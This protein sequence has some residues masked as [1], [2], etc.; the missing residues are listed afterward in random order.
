MKLWEFYVLT[1]F[2]NSGVMATR[3]Q[4]G[5]EESHHDE[6]MGDRAHEQPESVI[7]VP[8]DEEAGENAESV[9]SEPDEQLENEFE[10]TDVKD[11]GETLASV[12]E[13]QDKPAPETVRQRRPNSMIDH[14]AVVSETAEARRRTKSGQLA[15]VTRL[16]NEID[17]LMV[18]VTNAN[19]VLGKLGA[20]DVAFERLLIACDQC[21]E[22]TSV[23]DIDELILFERGE[24]LKQRQFVTN[25]ESWLQSVRKVGG[26]GDL[27]QVGA[28]SQARPASSLGS[29]SSRRSH[30]STK[31]AEAQV[32][33]AVARM[34]LEQ[35]Q[36]LN[37]L[38]LEQ[39]RCE[40]EFFRIQAQNQAD[41]AEFEVEFWAA[42]GEGSTPEVQVSDHNILSGG[43][44]PVQ[45]EVAGLAP[46]RDTGRADK[47]RSPA[48][49]T[50]AN[51]QG[52]VIPGIERKV[53]LSVLD[54]EAPEWKGSDQ[55][56]RAEMLCSQMLSAV[57]LPQPE[58]LT[59]DGD[60]A[61][62][63]RFIH[64]FDANLASMVSD[65]RKR[66][67][68][69]IQYCK[70][71]ARESI[72]DCILLDPAAGYAR[73]RQILQKTYGKPHVIARA[74]VGKLVNGPQ[75][76]IGDVKG[77]SQLSL[78]MRKAEMTLNQMGYTADLD[79]CENLMRIVRRLP[80]HLRGKW[81]DRADRLMEGGTEP[82]FGHLADFVEDR[83]RVANTL[84][85][86]DL[87]R[88]SETKNAQ[89]AKKYP[90]QRATTLATMTES[91]EEQPLKCY[92]CNGSHAISICEQFKRMT[93]QQRLEVTRR[94]RL[95]DNCFRPF[96]VSRRC[97][98]PSQCEE[99]G[100][101]QKHHTLM[102][103]YQTQPESSA[104]LQ[105]GNA[106]GAGTTQGRPTQGQ[107]YATEDGVPQEEPTEGGCYATGA[108][109]VQVRLKV[110]P[111]KVWAST[112][113][114]VDTYAMLDDCS[115]VTLCSRELAD[116]LGVKGTKT[117]FTLTTVNK[118]KSLVQSER[119]S[120]K[121]RG[122]Q[123]E[124]TIVLDR[125]LTVKK[126][127]VSSKSIPR[128]SD[129]YGWPH[130]EGVVLPAISGSD[131]S[132]IIGCD[133]PE[134]FWRLEERRGGKREP[135]A[136]L[137]PLGWTIIGPVG[138]TAS[139]FH[140]NFTQRD[141]VLHQQ[142][143]RLWK[144]DFI[145]PMDEGRTGM[146][147]E[148]KEALSIMEDSVTRTSDGH[149]QLSMPW[150]K[151]VVVPNDNYESAL[152]RLRGLKRRLQRDNDLHVK[153]TT[154]M[155]RNLEKGYAQ[156][157]PDEKLETVSPVW[158]L[159]HHPVLNPNKPG[160]VRIVFDCAAKYLGVSLNDQL[161]SGPDLTNNLTG[162]LIRFRQHSIAVAGDIEGMFNQVQ[163]MPDDRDKLRF[164]W[165]PEGNLSEELAAYQMLVH[166]FGAT[167]SPACATFALH[168]TAE[169]HKL[170]F[171]E[172]VST[173]VFCNFYVDD[174]LKSVPTEEEAVR[175]VLQLT[176]LL[177][178]GGFRM[179]KWVSN[180][181]KVIRSIPE[182]ARLH[183]PLGVNLDHS[184][185]M[186]KTLGIQWNV[187]EDHLQFSV[188]KRDKPTTRRGILSVISS[189]YDPLGFVA[190]VILP[191]KGLLQAFCQQK[192]G[193]DERVNEEEGRKWQEWVRGLDELSDLTIPRCLLPPWY[194]AECKLELHH[195]SDASESGYGAV[196]YL[197]CLSPDTQTHVSFVIGKSRLAPL[198]KVTIPRL[199]LSA[200][201]VAVKLD[202]IVMQEL[203]L[204]TT[205]I[206][207][208]DSI[209]VLGYIENKKTRF[210]TFVANRL[211]FIH[212]NTEASQWRYVDTNLNP[213]DLASR[214]IKAEEKTKLKRWVEGP[215]FL[216]EDALYW[217]QRPG[218][219]EVSSADPEVKREKAMVNF[220]SQEGLN[221]LMAI[222]SNWFALQGSVAWLL[223]FKEFFTCKYSGRK[224][225]VRKSQR[226]SVKE[227]ELAK[228]AIIRYVQAE[229]FEK[230]IPL[231]TDERTKNPNKWKPKGSLGKLCPI[232]EDGVL[233]V[234]GRL[235]RA[236]IS[237]EAKHPLILPNKHHVTDL[238]IQECHASE[239]HSG[240]DHV[241]SNLLQEF[242]IVKGKSAVRRVLS[243]C[244]HCRKMFAPPNTQLM[245]SLPVDRLTPDK[246]PLHVCWCRLLWAFACE[247][248][249]QHTKTIRLPV[250][251]PD[252]QSRASGSF[253]QPRYR[254]LSECLDA[255]HCTSW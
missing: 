27:N 180:N 220:T 223:R 70:G 103:P 191:A 120:L 241:L 100:C 88:Y 212:D 152:T 128:T 123:P 41:I 50:K 58:L 126:L 38:R 243:K 250:Y 154:E 203:D 214:G 215:E 129:T 137:T 184:P 217:P 22:I 74:Y 228:L 68:Y 53:P 242:W 114:T 48:G 194:T 195:F 61:S 56:M 97:W 196:T 65:D 118:S 55:S 151:G 132:L 179:T 121:V 77:L 57:H 177:K 209:T 75:I 200:A 46:V 15:H 197:R 66:L 140:V 124:E 146:S 145:E 86:Q 238:I 240:Q 247:A 222:H 82:K 7:E 181:L 80:L 71:E 24:K 73:A 186:E 147:V 91:R 244:F 33:K 190:P 255:F 72:E 16:R 122:I 159:P 45:Y 39:Q 96:H 117:N 51:V 21:R 211:S 54:P 225:P 174:C 136:A 116:K 193:W 199:E 3:N 44:E 227:M 185:P 34:K 207:W 165:W 155:E 5:E 6:H 182:E 25:V 189:V 138:G 248:R 109:S 98:K 18:S 102:H 60:P 111:V 11:P 78:L 125:A 85:G 143:E 198:K 205:S 233:R 178:L 175:L 107:V 134:A 36:K 230:D 135:Y 81:A 156:R 115:D 79:N 92:V 133:V 62:F 234:G 192:L 141:A 32:K 183:K 59:F 169:D 2:S 187:Q 42:Q 63:W 218:D 226:L 106:T 37:E 49:E 84:Y 89:V 28:A 149:Y 157:V 104:I 64:N 235:D 4:A 69:L 105:A 23:D 144:S 119:V 87:A 202:Q 40:A 162:V 237:H 163:V 166:L 110:V 31:L 236:D 172:Q 221:Q 101:Q 9:N 12:D 14:A 171:D 208:T 245:A 29:R 83:S 246:P 249:T 153:Y 201:V 204:P 76:K 35:L 108:G 13:T 254:L 188:V 148:D 93:F 8:D 52:K 170:Q 10:V 30:S 158:Y 20:L 17:D 219:L 142:V 113:E 139:E 67:S 168:K 167:S 231:H 210:K 253:P 232:M 99:Q 95:C 252:N 19:L 94:D 150:R 176:E 112:G 161:L 43:R 229:A 224:A 131:V 239:G 90:P 216:R 173:A 206:L 164:L 47:S 160:K 26:G 1:K 251:L 213:A 127:P 130:L